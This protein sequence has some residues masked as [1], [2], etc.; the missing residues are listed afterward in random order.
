M[1]VAVLND[2]STPKLPLRFSIF[3]GFWGPE[4]KYGGTMGSNEGVLL[5]D[6]GWKSDPH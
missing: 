1:T 2:R 5:V 3:L 6:E 4:G